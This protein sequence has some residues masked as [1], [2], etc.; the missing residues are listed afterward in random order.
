[1][2]SAIKLAVLVCGGLFLVSAWEEI[3]EV[4]DQVCLRGEG[5]T[6]EVSLTGERREGEGSGLGRLPTPLVP[7][8]GET[9]GGKG[10]FLAVGSE[11]DERWVETLE[12][13]DSSPTLR[14]LLSGST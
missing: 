2:S 11:V 7:G 14:L 9:K 13:D 1:M 10:T 3:E 8:V 12:L 6:G 4:S 5:T